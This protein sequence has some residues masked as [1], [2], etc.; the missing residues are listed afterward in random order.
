MP[1]ASHQLQRLGL[2]EKCPCEEDEQTQEV[3]IFD[4]GESIKVK[5]DPDS[6]SPPD[7][8]MIP[9]VTNKSSANEDHNID[10]D[11][12]VLDDITYLNDDRHPGK[13]QIYLTPQHIKRMQ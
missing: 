3:T 10:K 2:Y 4:R 6:F 9:S 11:T 5:V 8:N 13:P 7:L 1:I 12:F